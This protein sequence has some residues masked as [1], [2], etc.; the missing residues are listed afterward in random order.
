MTDCSAS[1]ASCFFSLFLSADV[2]CV[3][4]KAAPVADGR[5]VLDL[6]IHS[7]LPLAC[8]LLGVALRV[9]L[10]FLSTFRLTSSAFPAALRCPLGWGDRISPSVDIEELLPTWLACHDS[11]TVVQRKFE[12]GSGDVFGGNVVAQLGRS[13]NTTCH[14]PVTAG[15][16]VSRVLRV[17]RNSWQVND[18]GPPLGLQSNV[19]KAQQNQ[20]ERTKG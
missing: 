20:V 11:S 6:T 8:T 13:K 14:L 12:L 18:G 16:A 10:P 3:A 5:G 4:V 7:S 17:S 2:F 19:S 15:I 9:A 1:S